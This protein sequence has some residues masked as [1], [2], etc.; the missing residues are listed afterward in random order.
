ME[1]KTVLSMIKFESAHISIFYLII[2]NWIFLK[3]ILHYLSHN[4]CS[5]TWQPMKTKWQT[6]LTMLLTFLRMVV[7][8]LI[9]RENLYLEMLI[10]H[11]LLCSVLTLVW[12]FWCPTL[13]GSWRKGKEE[14]DDNVV[15]PQCYYINVKTVTPFG[16]ATVLS[17]K[18]FVFILTNCK[19]SSSEK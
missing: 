12:V 10:R 1:A 8:P 2:L 11:S 15:N 7:R 17:M 13:M 4:N 19:C 5:P 14:E 18:A 3:P 16:Y 9:T 6:I